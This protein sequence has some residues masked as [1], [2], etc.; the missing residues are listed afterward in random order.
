V[1]IAIES[2][3]RAVMMWQLINEKA[4][5]MG[6]T[7]ETRFSTGLLYLQGL[8]FIKLISNGQIPNY[9]HGNDRYWC[10]ELVMA[11]VNVLV[12]PLMMKQSMRVV[13]EN[14]MK[15]HKEENLSENLR[16]ARQ[17]AG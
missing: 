17:L 15:A 11:L 6:Q 12:N 1:I 10:C 14:F 7:L 4:P 16:E 5:T 3:S 2:H 8:K 13:K 9:L